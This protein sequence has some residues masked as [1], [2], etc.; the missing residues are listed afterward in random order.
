[1]GYDMT[2]ARRWNSSWAPSSRVRHPP[3]LLRSWPLGMQRARVIQDPL[4]PLPSP[5][6]LSP[7]S[8]HSWVRT[9]LQHTWW[10]GLEIRWKPG[11]KLLED[12]DRTGPTERDAPCD[13]SIAVRIV[14]VSGR[15]RIP[16][17]TGG[18]RRGERMRAGRSGLPSA[19]AG[20]G[21]VWR[22]FRAAQALA[23]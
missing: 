1:M 13:N 21:V 20:V 9:S 7:S 23:G 22:V 19:L 16:C 5:R 8:A 17:Y 18:E 4:H 15:E 11:E 12:K 6:P 3:S 14:A 10:D 2:C